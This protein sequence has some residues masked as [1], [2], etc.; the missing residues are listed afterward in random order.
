MRRFLPPR[1]FL[2]SFAVRVVLVWAFLRAMSLVGASA[3]AG[4]TV[5]GPLPVALL[6]APIV[7][8]VMFIDMTRRSEL[9]FLANLGRSFRGMTLVIL[10]ICVLAETV[11][12]LSIG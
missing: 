1:P 10:A 4:T 6:V 11:L 2:E 12:R 5:L 8:V 7:V 3:E 9:I